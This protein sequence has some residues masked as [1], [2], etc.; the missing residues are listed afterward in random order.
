MTS[1]RIVTPGQAMAMI[2]TITARAP[3]RI[4]D[5]DVD[6]NMTGL[7]SVG[8]LPAERA[9]HGLPSQRNSG[10]AGCGCVAVPVDD[11]LAHCGAHARTIRL[12]RGRSHRWDPWLTCPT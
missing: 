10:L 1:A 9:C 8:S 7:P 12:R 11:C 3:R 2:P 5:V 6:L 4:K